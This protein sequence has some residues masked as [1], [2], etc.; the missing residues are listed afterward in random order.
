MCRSRGVAMRRGFDIVGRVA[1]WAFFH[2]NSGRSR[3]FVAAPAARMGERVAPS[4][5][6]L[7]LEAA[8]SSPKLLQSQG[9]SGPSRGRAAAARRALDRA[10]GRLS[11]RRFWYVDCTSSPCDV[12]DRHSGRVARRQDEGMT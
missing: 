5:G 9:F 11:L 8:S 1:N 12:T 4:A 3:A 2:V 6:Q 7:H 10:D